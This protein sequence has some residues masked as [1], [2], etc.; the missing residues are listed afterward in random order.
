MVILTVGLIIIII[1]II[2]SDVTIPVIFGT[3]IVE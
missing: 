2:S 3:V 1:I